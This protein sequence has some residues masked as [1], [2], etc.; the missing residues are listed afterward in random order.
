MVP[1]RPWEPFKLDTKRPLTLRS[2]CR[3]WV[4]SRDKFSGASN[5]RAA[6][7]H[8]KRKLGPLSE[9]GCDRTFKCHRIGA[10]KSERR[11]FLAGC[12]NGRALAQMKFAI[13]VCLKLPS[14]RATMFDCTNN[15]DCHVFRAA[16]PAAR[17]S[18]AKI[19]I[20][21]VSTD[22]KFG[23]EASL[24]LLFPTRPIPHYTPYPLIPT[25]HSLRL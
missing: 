6:V 2:D 15:G 21:A 11:S 9:V 23:M 14:S 24:P 7:S 3:C 10:R 8:L 16:A 17:S 12:G 1:C 4:H 20:W 25:Y 13:E 22:P 18:N 19:P 5:S